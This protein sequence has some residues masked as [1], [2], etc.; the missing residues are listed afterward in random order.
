MTP[1]GRVDCD[2]DA[3]LFRIDSQSVE[4]WLDFALGDVQS[5]K[6][7]CFQRGAPLLVL[8]DLQS[9]FQLRVLVLAERRLHRVDPV[10]EL[11]CV[12]DRFAEH[13]L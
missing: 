1:A 4:E 11:L 8:L 6:P 13:G 3:A 7:P 9:F 10:L 2:C 12:V 5:R